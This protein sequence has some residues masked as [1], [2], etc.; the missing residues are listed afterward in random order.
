MQPSATISSNYDPRIG[1]FLQPDPLLELFPTQS[2]Y[3]YAYNS[4]L[5]WKDP[6]GLAGETEYKIDFVNVSYLSSIYFTV[7]YKF[8][9]G[10]P[11]EPGGEEIEVIFRN[12]DDGSGAGYNKSNGMNVQEKNRLGNSAARDNGKRI[13]TGRDNGIEKSGN[14]SGTSIKFLKGSYFYDKQL[15]TIFSKNSMYDP[16]IFTDLDD[17]QISRFFYLINYF[18]SRSETAREIMNTILEIGSHFGSIKIGKN[19]SETSWTYPFYSSI[20]YT[21]N[22]FDGKT[23]NNI[24]SGANI[25]HELIHIYLRHG[26]PTILGTRLNDCDNIL[27]EELVVTQFLNEILQEL[28]ISLLT[29]YIS[30]KGVFIIPKKYLLLPV[31]SPWNWRNRKRN[32]G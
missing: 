17:N 14:Y 18:Y 15:K 25:F 28:Y 16:I 8:K 24:T 21:K 2:S 13:R 27:F 23:F 5:N 12:L 32:G 1:R 22:I 31:N 7:I 29:K 30:P 4:P 20:K 9:L 3:S 11:I 6:S 19:S 26:Y 10:S